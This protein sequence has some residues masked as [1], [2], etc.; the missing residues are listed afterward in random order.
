MFFFFLHVSVSAFSGVVIGSFLGADAN[1][2]L[3][4][5]KIVFC[6]FRL[7]SVIILIILRADANGNFGKRKK[8][9][10]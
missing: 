4:R 8:S 6:F 1:G 2:I 5:E 3:K 7:A 10:F 9:I